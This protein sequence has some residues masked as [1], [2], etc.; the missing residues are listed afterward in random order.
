MANSYSR[1]NELASISRNT[2]ICGNKM[3][4]IIKKYYHNEAVKII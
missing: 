2:R 4:M 1:K 3:K